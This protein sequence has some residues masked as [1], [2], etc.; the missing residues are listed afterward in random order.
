[1][2]NDVYTGSAPYIFISYAHKDRTQVLSIVRK[3][4]G[5]GFRIWYDA[6]IEAGKRWTE[7][8]ARRLAYCK[9]VM[10]FISDASLK[11]PHCYDEIK[12]AAEQKKILI[13]IH[14]QNVTLPEKVQRLIREWQVLFRWKYP[15]DDALLTELADSAVIASCRG[16]DY[17]SREAVETHRKLAVQYFRKAAQWE[18]HTDSQFKLGECYEYGDGVDQDHSSAFMWYNLAAEEGHAQAQV[19]LAHYYRKGTVFKI[20][21][22]KAA[23]LYLKAAKRGNNEGCMEYAKCC[24]HGFGTE[25]NVE[26][27][28][29]WYLKAAERGHPQSQFFLALLYE[30]LGKQ[31][32]AAFWYQKAALTS[33]GTAAS[34][35][36]IMRKNGLIPQDATAPWEIAEAKWNE[37]QACYRDGNDAQ[38]V[39]LLHHAAELGH[40]DAQCD[41]GRCY[42]LGDGVRRN[43][44]TAV[45]WF[46][47]SAQQG[48]GGGALHLGHCFANGDGVK[49]NNVTAAAWYL[50]GA[51][52]GHTGAQF[53]LANCYRDGIGVEK[54]VNAAIGWYLYSLRE[55]GDLAVEVLASL[56]VELE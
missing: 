32:E 27:A 3:L 54:S 48:Y 53:S 22:A 5:Q 31:D 12:A 25:K 46:R 38:A 43:L 9:C 20:N 52:R 45:R 30:S 55:Q 56:G 21:D 29:Q 2:P 23:K 36:I 26:K 41:L 1:M 11:S 4:Q 28:I 50:E 33:A 13:P 24:E 34:A 18:G 47:R 39:E 42:Y 44:N 8:I 49:Q 17:S 6:G 16:V 51:R 14:M 35:D 19:N 10:I 15:D 7:D 40:A 37:A